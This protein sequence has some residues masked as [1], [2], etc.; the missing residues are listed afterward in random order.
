MHVAPV[1]YQ[2]LRD[3]LVKKFLLLPPENEVSGKV[4]ISEACVKNSVHKAGGGS[5]WP[6]PGPPR[7]QVHPPGPHPWDQAG[8]LPL[9]RCPL[10]GPGRYTPPNQVHHPDQVPPGTTPTPPDQVHPPREADS[11]IR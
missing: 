2:E 1:S 10:P 9:T 6:G 3:S 5:T 4:I 11:G 7:D 8:T